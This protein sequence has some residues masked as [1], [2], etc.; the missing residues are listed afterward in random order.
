MKKKTHSDEKPFLKSYIYM[1]YNHIGIYIIIYAWILGVGRDN[2]V[3]WGE[4]VR[5]CACVCVCVWKWLLNMKSHFDLLQSHFGHDACRRDCEWKWWMMH[6]YAYT[7]QF[8]ILSISIQP[9]GEDTCSAIG[10][11]NIWTYGWMHQ[12]HWYFES[13]LSWMNNEI[14]VARK[15]IAYRDWIYEYHLS[16]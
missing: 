4:C 16:G 9:V 14:V 12:N 15:K 10:L 1:Y 6:V 2:S 11:E 7:S 3:I 8:F 5:T 13:M